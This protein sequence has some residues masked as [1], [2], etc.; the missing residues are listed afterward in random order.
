MQFKIKIFE[1]AQAGGECNLKILI[2]N[3]TSDIFSNCT[4]KPFDFLVIIWPSKIFWSKKNS[5]NK[6]Q[7]ISARKKLVASCARTCRTRTFKITSNTLIGWNWQLT[8]FQPISKGDFTFFAHVWFRWFR[9]FAQWFRKNHQVADQS[10]SR[11]FDGH[12]IKLES[13]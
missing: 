6:C 7:M 12:I 2:L 4:R 3:C 1:I 5:L 8:V 13:A 9:L 10:G 11:I